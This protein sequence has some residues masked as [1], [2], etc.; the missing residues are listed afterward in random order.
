[1]AGCPSVS[2]RDGE[3]RCAG[4]SQG[5]YGLRRSVPPGRTQPE[6][7]IPASCRYGLVNRTAEMSVFRSSSWSAAFSE[8]GVWELQCRGL[9]VRQCRASDEEAILRIL[10]R[11]SAVRTRSARVSSALVSRA[12]AEAIPPMLRI[13][14]SALFSV[15]IALSLIGLGWRCA[16]GSPD[17]RR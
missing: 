9:D 6:G 13:A 2:V 4:E 15:G 7:W 3:R 10:R 17:T 5:P 12:V 16:N 14:T 8:I 1:M 11:D